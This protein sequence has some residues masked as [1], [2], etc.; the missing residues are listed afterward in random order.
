[1]IDRCVQYL[2][3]RDSRSA[4]AV[5]PKQADAPQ[6]LRLYNLAATHPRLRV[7]TEVES[8]AE[9]RWN[10]EFPELQGP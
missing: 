2:R 5:V 4:F 3:E 7:T 6:I 1:M 9:Q 10:I 8:T